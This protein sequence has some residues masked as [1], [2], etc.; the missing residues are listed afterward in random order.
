MVFIICLLKFESATD[1]EIIRYRILDTISES[2]MW[3]TSIRMRNILENKVTHVVNADLH[4]GKI[5]LKDWVY[6][7]TVRIVEESY[8]KLSKLTELTDDRCS[9]MLL[10]KAGNN[11]RVVN[12]KGIIQR[13]AY[14]ELKSC[15]NKE[16]VA[17]CSI[18]DNA[19]KSEING[20]DTYEIIEDKEF[21][22][23]IDKKYEIF[24]AKA[25]M[26]GYGDVSFIYRIENQE[27]KLRKYV[28][29]SRNILIPSFITGIMGGA[30][31]NKIID[32]LDLNEGLKV[33]GSRAFEQEILT[34][35]LDR[36]EIPS[37][38][39]LVGYKAFNNNDSL[40]DSS[41]MLTKHKFKLRSNKTIVLEQ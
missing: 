33:I 37:T 35:K 2:N 1:D 16:E 22:K 14:D 39:E 24:I 6:N 18:K 10:S 41:G 36:V 12:Y 25:L 19:E 11:Y 8:N 7:I 29:S 21:S 15:I 34:G 17:N 38:V 3:V 13:M 30:F 9:L 28:G 40:F 20:K 5:R 31:A 4:N 23:N 32:T 26:I 27:V